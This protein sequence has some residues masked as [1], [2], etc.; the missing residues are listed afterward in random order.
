MDI[1]KIRISAMLT[2][3]EFAKE[4]G[5]CLAIVQRWEQLGAEPSLKSKRKLRDFCIKYKIDFDI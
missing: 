5:V 2:Q 4:L 1:K 3:Q